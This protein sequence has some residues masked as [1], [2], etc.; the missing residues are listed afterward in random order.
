MRSKVRVFCLAALALCA[1]GCARATTSYSAVEKHDSSEAELDFFEALEK[2]Q[3]VTNNDALHTF[4]LLADKEDHWVTYDERV[5]EAKRRA[6][7]PS[8]FDEPAN[9]SATVGWIARVACILSDLSGGLSMRIF[10]PIPRYAVREL[11][12][13][14]VLVGKKETQGFSGLEFV[15]FLTRLDRMTHFAGAAVLEKL[16]AE[17][18][19]GESTAKPLPPMGRFE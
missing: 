1:A 9:E 2:S 13:A 17:E 14:Q 10:G 12:Y 3:V 11:A 8:S 7:L 19:V 15:D 6:W 16:P 18:T 4:F 5:A